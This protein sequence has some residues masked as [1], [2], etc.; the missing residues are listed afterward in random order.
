MVIAPILVALAAIFSAV[1][2]RVEYPAAFCVSIFK[3]KD[4]RFW[5]KTISWHTAKRVGAY[6]LD[7]WH[8]AKSFSIFCWVGAIINAPVVD[9]LLYK[10]LIFGLLGAIW[11]LVFNLFY[12]KLL[13]SK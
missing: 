12:N 1:M 10:L 2:D 11:I 5:L 9:G 6:K 4:Q 8:I 3:N 13:V 7:S